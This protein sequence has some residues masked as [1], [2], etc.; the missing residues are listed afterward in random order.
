MFLKQKGHQNGEHAI[1]RRGDPTWFVNFVRMMVMPLGAN[2]G[3]RGAAMA[4]L[5]NS[6]FLIVLVLLFLSHLV[7]VQAHLEEEVT[8]SQKLRFQISDQHTC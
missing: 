7:V 8:R 4:I 3:D 6:N 1:G 2:G 5:A